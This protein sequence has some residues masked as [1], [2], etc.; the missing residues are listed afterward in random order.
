NSSGRLRTHP[1]DLSWMSRRGARGWWAFRP[2]LETLEGRRVPAQFGV[3]WH[4][5]EHLSVSFVPDGTL[6]AGDRSSL[7][8]LLD[9]TETTAT[10]QGE[11]LRAFQTWAD[12]AR[13]NFSVVP[14]DGTPLGAPGPDQ[15]DSRFGDIR[16]G[17]RPMSPEVLAISVP[18]DPFLSGTWSGDILLN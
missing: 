17:A 8:G 6:I 14:D 12:A 4:D 3:P 7:F 2:G 9:G 10:R 16:I 5:P 1:K 18:H 15:G 11:I 13:V